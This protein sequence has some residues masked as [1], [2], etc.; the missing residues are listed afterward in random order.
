MDHTQVYFWLGVV[1][2]TNYLW[3]PPQPPGR[4]TVEEFCE[5]EVD[6]HPVPDIF[7][8]NQNNFDIVPKTTR[9]TVLTIIPEFTS[10]LKLSMRSSSQ[11]G[12]YW[13]QIKQ[14]L[15]SA[16]ATAQDHRSSELQ[17][18]WISLTSVVLLDACRSVAVG[19]T[20]NEIRKLHM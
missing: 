20:Q 6:S 18:H 1:R 12:D 3:I 16:A 10:N 15:Y 13:E 14:A 2:F 11:P 19:I 5:T 7:D 9:E 17:K 8:I 4:C